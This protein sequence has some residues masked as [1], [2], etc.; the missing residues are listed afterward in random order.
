MSHLAMPFRALIPRYAKDIKDCSKL[1]QLD[2]VREELDQIAEGR[3]SEPGHDLFRSCIEQQL[4]IQH[5]L[6]VKIYCRL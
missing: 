2:A 6:I 5:Q 3:S 1:S 4:Q